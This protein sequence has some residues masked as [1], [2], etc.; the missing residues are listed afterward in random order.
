MWPSCSLYACLLLSFIPFL[1]EAE[2][3][4]PPYFNIAGNRKIEAS[5]TCGVGV[6]QPELYCKLVGASQ[7]FRDSD[8]TLIDGQVCQYFCL[9]SFIL[10]RYF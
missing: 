8:N 5:S 10:Q 7:D 2:V 1:I 9:I 3:L 6:E 4:A